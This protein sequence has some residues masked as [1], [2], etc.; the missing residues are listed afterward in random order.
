MLS[1]SQSQS[2]SLATSQL[3]GHT[4]AQSVVGSDTEHEDGSE[5]EVEDSEDEISM[6]GAHTNTDYD[7]DDRSALEDGQ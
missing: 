4:P 7:D 6:H 1:Q 2:Q 5:G 3:S